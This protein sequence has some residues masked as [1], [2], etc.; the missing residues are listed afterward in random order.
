M[1]SN[2]AQADETTTEALNEAL[3][4]LWQAL[5]ARAAAD[6]ALAAARAVDQALDAASPA[7]IEQIIAAGNPINPA[8]GNHR[9]EHIEQIERALGV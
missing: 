8:R 2:V 7:L 9:A 3:L 1:D 5:P 6:E 4:P